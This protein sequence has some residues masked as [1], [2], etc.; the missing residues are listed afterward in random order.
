MLRSNTTATTT[1]TT[2]TT[3][4][5]ATNV[6]NVTRRQPLTNEL[7]PHQQRV[8][9]SQPINSF[10]EI[11]KRTLKSKFLK[12]IEASTS[13]HF[14]LTCLLLFILRLYFIDHVTFSMEW[15]RAGKS[16]KRCF[17]EKSLTQSLLLMIFSDVCV[18][19]FL[20]TEES[21]NREKER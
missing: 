11:L 9:T 10:S 1:A 5:A 12:I 18:M 2:A 21:L 19:T 6:T 4:T 14:F 7:T 17:K 3:A 15:K 20:F 16:W 13:H 8:T